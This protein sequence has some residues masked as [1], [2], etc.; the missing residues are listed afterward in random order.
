MGVTM[1]DAGKVHMLVHERRYQHRTCEGGADEPSAA[2]EHVN[3]MDRLR[4][5]TLSAGLYRYCNN[6]CILKQI[7]AQC[8]LAR[9][10]NG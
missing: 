4:C 8:S 1:M 6:L 3:C 10:R 9:C 5:D 2:L 7:V